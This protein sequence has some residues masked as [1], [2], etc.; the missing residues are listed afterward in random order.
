MSLN[1]TPIEQI[2]RPL[3][4]VRRVPSR[5]I[6]KRNVESVVPS[7]EEK[8]WLYETEYIT[9]SGGGVKGYSYAGA[10]LALDQAFFKKKINLYS[11]LKGASGASIGSMFALYLVLGVRGRQLIKEIM[12]TKVSDVANDININNVIEMK[13]FFGLSTLKREVF[14]TLEKFTGKGDVTFQELFDITGK[15]FVC[16]VTNVTLGRVEYHSYVNTPDFKVVESVTA[17]MCMPMFFVPN[18]I[19]GN[20]YVDGG[21]TDNCPFHVF[22]IEKTFVI[23]LSYG[24]VQ[25]NLSTIQDYI[26]RITSIMLQTSDALQWS[27]VPE[28]EQKRRLNMSVT[29]TSVI[30]IHIDEATKK[31]IVLEGGSQMNKFI[32]PEECV[33]Q[34]A[35]NIFKAFVMH[36]ISKELQLHTKSVTSVKSDNV[37]QSHNIG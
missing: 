10:I 25:P 17:S 4:N 5:I 33:R 35:Q 11:Q 20:H 28:N 9:F 22:P 14:N 18:I 21:V 16:S 30:N 3:R 15:E 26:M 34:Y 7:L 2:G 37:I 31:E 36:L 8:K 29:N 32:H 1:T 12:Q 19:N 6:A 23:S 24:T 13:G 27:M